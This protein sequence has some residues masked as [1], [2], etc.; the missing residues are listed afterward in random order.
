MDKKAFSLKEK[1]IVIF[2]V[3]LVLIVVF[4]FIWA[5]KQNVINY[6]TTSDLQNLSKSIN[7]YLS[8]NNSLPEMKWNKNYFDENWDY[9]ENKSFWINCYNS[10]YKRAKDYENTQY[11]IKFII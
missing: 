3:L 7:N 11:Y 8:E 4:S 1:F 6:K 9:S 5:K 10:I 2:L